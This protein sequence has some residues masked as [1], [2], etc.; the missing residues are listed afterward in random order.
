MITQCLFAAGLDWLEMVLPVLFV[1]FWIV[2]Q[3][4][5]AF[6]AVGR[7]GQ[8]PPVVRPPRPGADPPRADEI[9]EQLERQIGDFL[10][11][12]G[13][14]GQPGER[15]KQPP[16][17]RP[18]ARPAAKTMPQPVTKTVAS[19]T[20]PRLPPAPPAPG[21]R[22]PAAPSGGDVARHVREAFAHEL[23]HLSPQ[24]ASGA[25]APGDARRPEPP[26]AAELV[27]MLHNPATLRQLILLREVLDRPTDRW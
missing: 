15:P 20:P 10:R 6:R 18:A 3:V 19:R 16:E 9:R 22:R 5:N 1:L 27:A 8:R 17:Q 26:P 21:D 2:S 13:R 23:E 4:F 24:I 14:H 7:G 12:A 11:Q 25:P